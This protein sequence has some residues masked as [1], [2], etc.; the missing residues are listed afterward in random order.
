MAGLSPAS[1]LGASLRQDVLLDIYN[2]SRHKTITLY[3][4]NEQQPLW[5]PGNR[6]ADKLVCIWWLEGAPSEVIVTWFYQKMKY[7]GQWTTNST[8]LPGVGQQ[9]N[10]FLPAP[11]DIPW[12]KTTLHC[13]WSMRI[14]PWWCSLV[15]TGGG[16]GLKKV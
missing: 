2:L 13:P 14:R 15:T 16:E 12:G 10:L 5:Y 8:M 7:T 4:V 3:H 9:N 1:D 11:Q 6:E